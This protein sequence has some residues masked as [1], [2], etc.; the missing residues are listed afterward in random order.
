MGTAPE[1]ANI[2]YTEK[3][4]NEYNAI[5]KNLPETQDYFVGNGRD[6]PNTVFAG[7]ILKPWHE[8]KRSQMQLNPIIQKSVG[9]IAGLNTVVFPLPALPVGDNSLPLQ[10][11]VMSTGDYKSLYEAAEKIKQI[12]IKSGLFLFIDNTLKYNKPELEIDI[13]RSKAAQLGISMQDIGNALAAA[14]GGNYINLFGIEG[15]S[16]Q[17]IPQVLR[18]FRLNPKEIGLNYIT[19]ASGTL[20]PLSTIVSFAQT[21]QPNSLTQFQQQNA[22]KLQGLMLPGK[23]LGEGIKFLQKQADKILSPGMSY[24]YAG[25]S[26]Q[27]IQEGSALIYS[28]F[29][30]II[31]IFLVLAAQFESFRDPLIILISVPMSI[32]G[33]LIPLYLGLATINIYTQI[34]LITLIGLISKHGILMVDFANKLQINSGLDKREAI[35]QAAAIRLR[36]I[37][38]TTA[39]MIVGVVPLLFASGAGAIS[40][41][42]IGLVIAFGMAIGTMFTLFVVPTMYTFFAIDHTKQVLTDEE[43]LRSLD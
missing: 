19:T 32:C 42:N 9:N 18:Y 36:P 35:E 39:A 12:A 13:N 34:G 16:Y 8:R 17:V 2:D 23:T 1:Y 31:V 38:M 20:V 6:G 11:V 26:R 30:A 43:E 15:Q 40:R 33:A 25:Q 7:V 29:F 4:S 3:F 14:M 21:V 28:F 27:F 37:L 24:D 41:F 10:F 5:F 22:A